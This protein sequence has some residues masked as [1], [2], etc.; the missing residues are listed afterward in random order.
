MATSYQQLA[1][2][3]RNKQNQRKTE[4]KQQDNNDEFQK[5]K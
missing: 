1:E 4:L 5:P 3:I 2:S